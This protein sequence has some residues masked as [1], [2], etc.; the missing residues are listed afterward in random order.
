MFTAHRRSSFAP[1]TAF[2]ITSA[3]VGRLL[4]CV[5]PLAATCTLHAGTPG[6]GASDTNQV[7]NARL[8]GSLGAAATADGG[9]VTGTVPSS[10]RA[11]AL[12]DSAIATEIVPLAGDALFPGSPPTNAIRITVNSFGVGQGFDHANTVFPVIPGRRYGL[13]IYLRSGNGDSSP[14]NVGVG[15]PLFDQNLGFAGREPGNASTTAGSDWAL[16]SGPEFSA[17]PGDAFGHLSLRL[18]NDGGENSILMAL[19]EVQGLPLSN[20]SPNP[21]FDGGGGAFQGQVLGDIPDFWRGFAVGSGSLD[22][23]VVAVAENELFPGSP[24]TQAVRL[25]VND[26]DGG[27]EGFDHEL[28]RALLQPGHRYHG[29][30]WMRSGNSGGASQAVS[31]AMPIFDDDGFTGNAPGSIGVNVGA[32]WSLYAGPQFDAVEGEQTNLA[33][34][35]MADGGDDILLIALPRIVGPPSQMIYRD[36]FETE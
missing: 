28:F 23:N 31:V 22:V 19:P 13:Q 29:E 32:T 26:G 11:F 6:P 25:Q 8:H 35:L 17:E 33:F 3:L 27:S 9:I 36:R 10:W 20:L 18:V 21:T 14:Q 24:A 7:P 30:A 5:L 34:R 2:R 12:Q 4:F 1:R 15:F 16:V